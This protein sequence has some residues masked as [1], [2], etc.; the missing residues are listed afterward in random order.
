MTFSELLHEQSDSIIREALAA[1]DRCGL[2]HY[3]EPDHTRQ[4][5]KALLVL[6]QRALRDRNLG[7]MLAHAETIAGER[8]QAGFDLSEVQTAFNVLEEVIWKR[9]VKHLPPDQFADAFGMLS[10]VLG[11]GKDALACAY[12]SLASRSKVTSLDLEEL[13]H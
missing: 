12:V 4:R 10:T 6:T 8:F 13:F 9:I 2:R 7:P 5:M 3:R 1:V 11:A